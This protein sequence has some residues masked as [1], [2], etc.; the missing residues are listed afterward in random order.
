MEILV[1]AN[2]NPWVGYIAPILFPTVVIP[3]CYAIGEISR[4]IKK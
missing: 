3:I 4:I 2:N 1:W